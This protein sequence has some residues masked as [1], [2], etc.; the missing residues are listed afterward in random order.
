MIDYHYYIK[1]YQTS[2]AKKSI[3]FLNYFEGINIKFFRILL[4]LGNLRKI[5][6]STFLLLQG[7]IQRKSFFNL[8]KV[9][10]SRNLSFC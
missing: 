8:R 10:I 3:K 9:V 6:S 2:K 5:F 4:I 7:L 1:S